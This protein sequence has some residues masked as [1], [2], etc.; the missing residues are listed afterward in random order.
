MHIFSLG[1]LQRFSVGNY[2]LETDCL[3]KSHTR[4]I[5]NALHILG[6][7]LNNY[8]T[9]YSEW[10]WICFGT[11][12]RNFLKCKYLYL[13]GKVYKNP[14]FHPKNT[15]NCQSYRWDTTIYRYLLVSSNCGSSCSMHSP[16]L[17]SAIFLHFWSSSWISLFHQGRLVSGKNQ[18]KR[19]A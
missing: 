18:G 19:L 16:P 11:I 10:A 4:L 5:G 17:I 8:I 2:H 15:L 7:S 12:L 6:L 1:I 13:Q 14:E 3:F 9:Q